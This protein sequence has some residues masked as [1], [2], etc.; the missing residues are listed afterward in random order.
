MSDRRPRKPSWLPA[1][2][3]LCLVGG[4]PV[5][6]VAAPVVEIVSPSPTANHYFGHSIAV[7]GTNIVVGAADTAYLVD[8]TTGAVLQTYPNPGSPTGFYYGQSVAVVGTKVV[9]PAPQDV[10]VFDLATGTLLLSIPLPSP[11]DAFNATVAALGNDILVGAPGDDTAG[12]SAGAVYLFDG[13]TGALLQTFLNPD[14]DPGEPDNVLD[15]FGRTIAAVGGNVL[16]GDAYNDGATLRNLGTVYLFDGA[17]GALL[18]TIQDPSPTPQFDDFFGLAVAAL[19]SNLVV[20]AAHAAYLLDGTTG[21]V[22]QTF[23]PAAYC[24]AAAASGNTV[25]F[26][27]GVGRMFDAT[28]GALLRTLLDPTPDAFEIG[29]GNAVALLGADAVVGSY[30]DGT[31]AASAGAVYRFAGGTTGCGPC[32]TPNGS[33]TCGVGPHPT[34]RAPGIPGRSPLKIKN[35]ADDNRDYVLWRFRGESTMPLTDFGYPQTTMDYALCVFSESGP[36]SLVFRAVA[37]AGGLC[38]G[39][40]CWRAPSVSYRYVNR[41]RTPDGLG[42][43]ALIAPG[44][45]VRMKVRGDD[46][47]LSGRPF[48]LPSLPLALPL[49]VQLQGQDGACWEA[50]YSTA[51]TNDPTF[52]KATSD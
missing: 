37:P 11:N 45:Q 27:C 44:R 41:D 1:L 13:T 36:P 21:A 8:P 51:D 39:Q 3:M 33:G 50:T 2:L 16:V 47:N 38:R 17:T 15:E 22:L 43:V 49:R 30:L 20:T 35:M 31:A 7:A 5:T 24:P 34:C 4:N 26:G 48:G 18:L 32:E 9:I 23:T 25:L 12:D 19:G 46:A 29:F 10:E 42:A 52:F 14:P 40:P 28:S 6:G